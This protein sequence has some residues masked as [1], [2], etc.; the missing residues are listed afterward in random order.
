[1]NACRHGANVAHRE[2]PT[3]ESDAFVVARALV[4]FLAN[5]CRAHPS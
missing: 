1:M 3:V 2:R 5:G 4:L